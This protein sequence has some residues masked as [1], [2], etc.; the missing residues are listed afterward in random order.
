MRLPAN[1]PFQNSEVLYANY[2]NPYQKSFLD[3][4]QTL[5]RRL[6]SA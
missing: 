4:S 6:G 1:F 5:N 3:A 2:L